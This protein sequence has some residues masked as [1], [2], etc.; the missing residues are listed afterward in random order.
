MGAIDSLD[1]FGLDELLIFAFYFKNRERYRRVA[2]IGANL[3]LHSIVLAK[4][5]FEVDSYEPDP[6]H[7]E[8]L[9][10][11]L[12]LNGVSACN[13]Y[14]K[15]VSDHEGTMEFVRVLGNTTSSHLAGAKSNPYGK[16]EKFE[17]IVTD[18]K[19]I[20]EKVDLLKIDAEGHEAVLL[21]SIADRT[22]ENV[23]AFVEVGSPVN[24][25]LIFSRFSDTNVNIFAQKLGWNKVRVFEDMP[26][27]YK[28]G[29]I[30]I[31][32]KSQMCW[33]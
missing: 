5:G 27:S 6:S 20:S 7:F 19:A 13:P 1:L 26:T 22:W 12:S 11:N 18:I 33:T 30:F 10:R 2:D 9:R 25:K 28:E 16:L 8:K 31:T 14:Q 3:G 24:A 29:G 17:V 23:D 15:A 21:S 32:T 4:C